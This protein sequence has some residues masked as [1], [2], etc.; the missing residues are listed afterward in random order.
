MSADHILVDPWVWRCSDTGFSYELL[1]GHKAA[2]LQVQW[3][4]GRNFGRFPWCPLLIRVYRRNGR[5]S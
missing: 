1:V 5:K 4:H 2:F 3:C